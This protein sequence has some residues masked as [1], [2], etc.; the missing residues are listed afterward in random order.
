MRRIKNL[1][2]LQFLR[3]LKIRIFLI[4]FII[5]L[6][7]CNM[8]RYAIL[9]NYEQRAVSLRTSDVQTQLVYE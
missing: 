7:S 2:K 6:L 5:G 8:M 1:K 3:S 4:A 9:Q